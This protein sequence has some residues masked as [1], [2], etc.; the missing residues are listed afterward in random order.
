MAAC[1]MHHSTTAPHAG[2]WIAT[3]PTDHGF[4]VVKVLR[5]GQLDK[6]D[7]AV[8]EAAASEVPS[9]AWERIE[10]PAVSA[11]RYFEGSPA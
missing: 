11:K 2:W 3:V 6:A 1:S 7:E 9:L 4:R 5:D 10:A 8:L